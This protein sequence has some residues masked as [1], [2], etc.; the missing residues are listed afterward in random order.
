[1]KEQ[2][3]GYVQIKK[4]VIP[5]ST[6]D[7]TTYFDTPRRQASLD[8]SPVRLQRSSSPEKKL[9]EER[10]R[11]LSE[12]KTKVGKF[13]VIL[14]TRSKHPKITEI[15]SVR[16][17]GGEPRQPQSYEFKGSAPTVEAVREE[18]REGKAGEGSQK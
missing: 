14:E 12:R 3:Q 9:I 15:L 10:V 4:S 5:D 18:V 16:A 8:A 2:V 17:K 6:K 11:D 13:E 1:M 7:I